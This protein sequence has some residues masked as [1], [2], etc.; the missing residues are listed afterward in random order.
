MQYTRFSDSIAPTATTPAVIQ[1]YKRAP[2]LTQ[3]QRTL[4]KN[5]TP[6]SSSQRLAQKQAMNMGRTAPYSNSGRISHSPSTV[7]TAVR[8]VRNGG[9]TAPAKKGAVH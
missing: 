2:P 6:L 9:C 3:T 1:K 5:L 4:Q 8:R 7:R